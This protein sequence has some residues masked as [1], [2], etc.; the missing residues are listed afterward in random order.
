MVRTPAAA[1]L[2]AATC[3]AA[4]AWA[5]I[6]DPPKSTVP[7][8]LKVVGTHAGV[9]DP[10]G[11]FTVTVRD[12]ANNPVVGHTV[13]IDFGL[14]TDLVLC[15]VQPAGTGIDCA[16]PRVSVVTNAS[17]QAAFFVLGGGIVAGDALP[18]AIAPGA[19]ASCARVYDEGIQLGTVTVV[20][21]DPNGALAGGN[22]VTPLD[23]SI[24]KNDVGAAG[25]GA[26]YRG[27]ADLSLDGHLS[28]LDLSF[29]KTHVGLAGLGQGSVSGCATAAGPADY[30]P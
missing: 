26:P 20:I 30:C 4:A 8:Y 22:G 23:L 29:M 24:V 14:C 7:S 21:L 19:G 27:R 11:S 16:G 15:A 28:P 17:G 1:F 6:P 10:A 3:F 25:L 5:D 13:T 2:L 18:P 12:Y 9:P